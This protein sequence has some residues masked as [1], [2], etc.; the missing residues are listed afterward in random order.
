M[1]SPEGELAIAQAIVYMAVTAKSNAVYTAFKTAMHDA[2]ECG[3]L[4]VPLHLRNAPTKL[5]RSMGYGKMY[6][7]DHDEPDAFSVGQT[8]F[9]EKMGEKTYYKPTPRGLE[10]RILEK[11]NQLKALSKIKDPAIL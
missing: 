9:P 6:R 5:M 3:S 4:P 2:K 1:G 11:L 7:Y 10:G 8:Y